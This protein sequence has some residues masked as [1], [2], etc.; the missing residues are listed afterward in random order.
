MNPIAK[1]FLDSLRA[2]LSS[3]SVDLAHFI[4]TETYLRG[5]RFSFEGHEYQRYVVE[6]IRNNPGC[7]FVVKKSSQIGL[8]EILTRIVLA[9]MAVRPGTS[10]LISYPSKVFAQEML[11]T[12]V[13]NVIQ[14]S[15]RLST[16]INP[17]I[18]SASVKAFYNNSI[19]YALG[20]SK[21]SNTSLLNRP[22]CTV[23]A[24]E[25]DRQD[26]DIVS[27]YRSRMTHTPPH[28][29]FIAYISTP[30]AAGL[31]I[32][33]EF[34]E[35]STTHHP[36]T[37]CEHCGHQ[38][39]PDYY[40]HVRVPGYDEN[41]L[42]LTK[43]KAATLEIDKAYLEC[44]E[45]LKPIENPKIVWRT[46]LNPR[47]VRRKIG[48]ELNPFVAHSFI[49]M[50]DLVESSLTYQSHVEF[51]NQGL[52][53][54]ATAKDSSIQRENIHVEHRP[55]QPAQRIFACDMGKL[56]HVMIGRLNGDT[57]MHIDEMHVVKLSEIEEFFKQQHARYVFS[58]G[59]IDSQPY[60]DLVYRL[61]KQYPRLYSAIYVSPST[62]IPELFKL[63]M[64]DQYNEVVR[65]VTI[66]KAPM[67]DLM[68]NS[69]NSFVTFEPSP[70][71]GL[72]VKHLLDM[73]RV[74]DYRFEEMIYQWVKSKTGE[75]HFFHTLVYFFTAAKLAAA[76]LLTEFSP[77]LL[78]RKMKINH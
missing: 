58:A 13:A 23:L 18:D 27:G 3:E 66:N 61:V 38:F 54:V 31:G 6:V 60:S 37:V 8:T 39:Q 29:R 41:L 67:M 7:T 4:V 59:V 52:G 25:L 10:A 22:I 47:G 28:E 21:S 5:Q 57:T 72:L 17:N 24:D 34:D 63:K 1:Q 2:Q 14:E 11:K 15:P 44:P 51:L 35:C 55:D 74:R 49:S 42:L 75:D 53:R 77:P 9:R 19:L 68:A 78:I 65:Q 45:C 69:L 36:Y 50:P 20:G 56:C 12:R 71:E 64:T 73:R 33:A 43:S 30:T 40:Q 62:P 32:D 76:E 70:M 26:M 48:I 16:L 46:Q